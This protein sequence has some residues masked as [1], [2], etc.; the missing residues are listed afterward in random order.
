VLLPFALSRLRCVTRTAPTLGAG[1]CSGSPVGLRGVEHPA[2][3]AGKLDFI[4][5]KLLLC[6][7]CRKHTRKRPNTSARGGERPL[8]PLSAASAANNAHDMPISFG[9]WASRSLAIQSQCQQRVFL[10]PKP[11]KLSSL[12]SAFKGSV[13][14]AV[15][16]SLIQ[17]KA[18][19]SARLS[20]LS[21]SGSHSPLSPH[22]CHGL[23][24]L[25]RRGTNRASPKSIQSNCV[26]Y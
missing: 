9:R 8:G 2:S 24:L 13:R 16:F 6:R 17:G 1:L 21:A 11:Q 14:F 3:Q 20:P 26:N 12:L 15:A 22:S 23:C 5:F 25:L 18:P 10:L 4:P 19:P 7:I